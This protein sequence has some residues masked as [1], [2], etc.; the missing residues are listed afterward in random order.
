MMEETEQQTPAPGAL[1]DRAD[2]DQIEGR[3]FRGKLL[4]LGVGNTAE[5]G[6]RSENG[7]QPREALRPLAEMGERGL[8]RGVFDPGE[9]APPGVDRDEG[10]QAGFLGLAQGGR[11]LRIE[12]LMDRVPHMTD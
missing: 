12:R 4:E 1:E 9:L 2:I 6:M 7:F 8:A 10:I 3:R 5:K 11:Y